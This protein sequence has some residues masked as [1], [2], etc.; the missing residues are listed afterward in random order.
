MIFSGKFKDFVKIS[1]PL[2]L[3]MSSSALMVS[4]NRILLGR[5]DLEQY[6][7]VF[8]INLMYT[9]I[10]F[11]G[12][13][14]S[15][16][17]EV[18]CGQYNGLGKYAKVA[19]PSWQM[20]YFSLLIA[21][22]LIVSG[23]YGSKV[24]LPS[25]AMVAEQY[26]KIIVS[27]AFL[28]FI[29]TSLQSFFIGIGHTKIVLF[30][31]LG[32]HICNVM[33]DVILIYGSSGLL[34]MCGIQSGLLYN[35]LLA[36]DIAE[37][38]S[39]GA[40]IATATSQMLSILFLLVIFLSDK[41]RTV[42][43]TNN[44]SFN[45]NLFKKCLKIGIP[46]SIGH[47]AEMSAWCFIGVIMIKKSFA[48]VTIAN[49]ANS[50]VPLF[51]FVYEGIVK[52]CS[53][54]AA[55]LIGQKNTKRILRLIISSMKLHC[56]FMFCAGIIL[57]F[58]SSYIISLFVDITKLDVVLIG[59]STISLFGVLL[60]LIIDGSAWILSSVLVAGGDTKFTMFVNTSTSWVLLVI[61]TYICVN[62]FDVSPIIVWTLILPISPIVN[63]AIYFMR[64]KSGRWCTL[65]L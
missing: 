27:T 45:Y 15:S 13:G 7:A 41:Y 55:N 40:A 16:I 64:Y 49:I 4:I 61:P 17:A 25:E 8:V 23:V 9:A 50:I 48:H 46:Q 51:G 34:Q 47:F 14:I 43:R 37:Y 36:L 28:S 52:A 18:F 32:E 38:G 5:Y 19:S 60:Y 63:L 58:Y 11:F 20:I 29:L 31:V 2:I 22:L 39:S 59:A 26:Y 65:R 30:V 62:F 12:T 1:F 42:Y 33:L 56:I 53:T 10:L 35:L 6:N 21:P 44:Y 24:F 3:S 57:Y 54:V